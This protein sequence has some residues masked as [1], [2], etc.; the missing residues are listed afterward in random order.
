MR[1]RLNISCRLRNL[2]T[3]GISSIEKLCD[4]REC[5]GNREEEEEGDK[6]VPEQ[7]LSFI[8]AHTAYETYSISARQTTWNN[9][10]TPQVSVR[11]EL[12]TPC[13]I[14]HVWID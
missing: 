14:F 4:H 11:V 9:V 7:L 2:A 1:G 13:W 12:R 3:C 10:R 5:D 6:H 8:K